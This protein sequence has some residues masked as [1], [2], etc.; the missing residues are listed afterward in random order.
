M[1][2]RAE[3]RPEAVSAVHVMRRYGKSSPLSLQPVTES[4][5]SKSVVNICSGM[6]VA[7]TFPHE[8]GPDMTQHDTREQSPDSP[9]EMSENRRELLALI[10][11]LSDCPHSVSP[12]D[13]PPERVILMSR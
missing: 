10:Q 12:G 13:A 6:L 7:D 4:F 1:W 3:N 8:Q 2:L 11:A 9:E 5:I